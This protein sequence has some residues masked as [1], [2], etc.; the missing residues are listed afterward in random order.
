M[1]ILRIAVVVCLVQSNL[2]SADPIAVRKV[3]GKFPAKN[4]NSI[5]TGS[6]LLIG[7]NIVITNRHVVELKDNVFCDG[8]MVTTGPTYES[9]KS[10]K[11][12]LIYVSDAYDLAA[13]E[14][15]TPVS[16]SSIAVLN[17]LPA[18]GSKVEA[19][20]FPLSGSLGVGLTLS[21]GQVSRHPVLAA[22]GDS[23]EKKEVKNAIWHDAVIASG[24]SGGPLFG[25]NKVLVGLNF[26]HLTKGNHS[27]CV[28]GNAICDFVREAQ[29]PTNVVPVDSITS[30][31]LEP[32]SQDQVVYIEAF[33]KQD[34]SSTNVPESN[35]GEQ[36]GK[37]MLM[38][39]MAAFRSAT[40]KQ[41]RSAM[42][43]DLRYLL[44]ARPA[45]S[46]SPGELA[47]IA[48]V[49]DVIEIEESSVHC[50]IDSVNC[51]V[52]VPPSESSTMAAKIGVKPSSE[53]NLDSVFFVGNAV[54]YE[55]K[56]GTSFRIYL[57][58]MS[59][60]LEMGQVRKLASDELARR[61]SDT[62][63]RNVRSK[64]ENCQEK[65]TRE[66]K[67][68]NGKFAVVATCIG[69]ADENVSLMRVA[70]KKELTV[71]KNTLSDSD[72]EWLKKNEKEIGLYGSQLKDFLLAETK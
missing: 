72:K 37:A 50:F 48:G 14:L 30:P 20:G 1:L 32:V 53:F 39:V 2:L 4:L 43:G 23:D 18:L 52:I 41:I 45:K 64:M 40:T 29:I 59:S 13:L 28:P 38:S 49:L 11:A 67:S 16:C 68:S 69:Y 71:P 31:K 34:Y 61:A 24:S 8:F 9:S 66:F 56:S 63:E 57:V 17:G 65:F 44:P 58:S 5:S 27:L 26:A 21:G 62:A 35:E 47:R 51:L 60:F 22:K 6:G 3:E 25:E 70:D 10:L 12:R 46:V 55:A 42:K 54:P 36:I 7:P 33:S 15:E 19:Y